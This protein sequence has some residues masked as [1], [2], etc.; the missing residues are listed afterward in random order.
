MHTVVGGLHTWQHILFSDESRFSLPSFKQW[1]L[2]CALQAWITFLQTSVC[3]SPTM[4]EPEVLW[5]GLCW[6]L[7]WWSHSA[8]NSST[9]IE[10]RKIPTRHSWS[11]RSAL[12]STAKLWSRLSTWQ[13]KVSRGPCLSRLSEPESHPCSS[14]LGLSTFHCEYLQ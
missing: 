12:P 5:S 11:Y 8:Q 4:L 2:S 14:L 13:C 6:N 10:C 1:T 9:A 7:S 3:T